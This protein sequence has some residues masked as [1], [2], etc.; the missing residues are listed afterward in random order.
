MEAE[1][2]AFPELYKNGVGGPISK[3]ED[4]KNWELMI[5]ILD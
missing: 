4:P 5:N 2:L 3:M 1:L